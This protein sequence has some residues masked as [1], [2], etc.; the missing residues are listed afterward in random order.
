MLKQLTYIESIH[1]NPYKNLAAEEHLLLCCG[2]EEYI[3]YLWQN[4][5]TVVI[6]RNQNAWKE[7]QVSRLE[8][9]G[10]HLARRLSGGGAVYHDLGNLNFTFA[11]HKKNYSVDRQMKVILRALES[12]GI[13]G[14]RSGRND[15]LVD[16]KKVSG[17]AFYE[18][19][20][21]CYHHGTLMVDVDMGMLSRYLTVSKE[22][23]RSNGVDSVRS[24]VMNLKE[25]VPDLTVEKLKNVLREAFEEEFQMRSVRLT[26]EDLEKQGLERSVEKFSS[27]DWIYGR[28][29]EFQ[30]EISRKF[31]WGQISMQFHVRNGIIEEVAVYSDALKT[32]I[33]SGL[34]GYLKGIRYTRDAVCEN[35]GRYETSDPGESEILEEILDWIRSLDF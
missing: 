14:E 3:L 10:G 8:D 1:L 34:P 21:R 24:R 28:R 32:E 22:K 12:L 13:H 18:K 11:A 2:E 7:C 31:V 35:L 33:I 25:A 15:I 6:G 27:W 23:L 30:N 9:E 16:G 26:M 19:G 5:H 4:S 29:M 20:D 17:H